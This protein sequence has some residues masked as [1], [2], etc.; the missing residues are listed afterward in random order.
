MNIDWSKAPEGATHKDTKYAPFGFWY[1]FDF[2]RDTAAYCPEGESEWVP[3]GKASQYNDGSMDSMVARPKEVVVPVGATHKWTCT[4]QY[5]KRSGGKTWAIWQDHEWLWIGD[6]L[7]G[8]MV[9]LVDDRE[10]S[11]LEIADVLSSTVTRDTRQQAAEAIYDAGYRK[12]E[13]VEEDV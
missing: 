8:E 11:I 7:K 3:S 1:K 6:E 12:F 5:A 2:K 13:I 4:G 10:N 9:P